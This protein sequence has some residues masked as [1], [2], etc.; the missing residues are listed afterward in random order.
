MTRITIILNA[1]KAVIYMILLIIFTVLVLVAAFRIG[2]LYGF[3]S[4]TGLGLLWLKH[5]KIEDM[6]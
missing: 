1:I 2:T 4:I 3:I 6:K 5:I